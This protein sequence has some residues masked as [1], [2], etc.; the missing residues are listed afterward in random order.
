[1]GIGIGSA[2]NRWLCQNETSHYSTLLC[3]IPLIYVNGPLTLAFFGFN[4]PSTVKIP[5]T[6]PTLTLAGSSFS[7]LAASDNQ[8]TL[9]QEDVQSDVNCTVIDFSET[10][11]TCELSHSLQV[12]FVSATIDVAGLLMEPDEPIIISDI[13]IRTSHVHSSK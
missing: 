6:T 11:L 9:F 5:V 7:T 8:L 13:D 1:V 10:E 4:Q 3:I 12:G 2:P